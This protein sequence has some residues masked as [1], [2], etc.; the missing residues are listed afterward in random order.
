MFRLPPSS[1]LAEPEGG[2][3]RNRKGRY[4]RLQIYVIISLFAIIDVMISG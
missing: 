4:R 2:Q 1:F 3:I